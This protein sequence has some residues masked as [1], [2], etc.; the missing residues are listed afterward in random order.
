MNRLLCLYGFSATLVAATYKVEIKEPGTG[1]DKPI[2]GAWIWTH[3]TGTVE[4]GTEFDSTL[5]RKPYKF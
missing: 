4:S 5:K 3:Y 2:D 1:E